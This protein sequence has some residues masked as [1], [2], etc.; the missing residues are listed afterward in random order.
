LKYEQV[1]ASAPPA[2]IAGAFQT[3]V[4]GVRSLKRRGVRAVMF[5][6]V[7][8]NPGFQSVYGPA[9]ACP[10]PDREPEAWRDFMLGLARQ[11]GDRPVLIPSSDKFVSAI[12]QHEAALAPHYRLSPGAAL[13]GALANKHS[14]YDLAMRFGMPMPVTRFAKNEDDVRDFARNAMFPCLI[15]PTH[16]REWQKLPKDHRLYDTKVAIAE[17]EAQLI[18]NYRLAVSV[19]PDVILQEIIVGPDTAK[20]VYLSCYDTAGKRIANAMFRELRCSPVGFGPASIS[21]P[22]DDPQ[23]DEVCDRWLRAINYVGLCEIEMKWDVRDGKVKI[24]EA[25]PR[26]SGGGDAAP[27]AGV[28]LPWI[29]YCDL[30]GLPV[31]PA[32]PNGKDFRH[33]VLRADGDA[34]PAYWFGG[35]IGFR[36]VLASYR[37]PRAFFDLDR[38]DWRYSLETFY[39][40]GRLIFRALVKRLFG[41]GA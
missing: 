7:T 11:L 17:N 22:V 27:Y 31:T 21:E 32:H 14:Q 3:G 19:T 6:S 2:V 15:K 13:Q 39:V 5:D 34:L 38:R 35:L 25:N 30:A 8:N 41:R 24:I 4:L 23:T 33:I 36:D 28:D 20:R 9:I 18:Q 37:G 29:Q 26:L 12:A 10:D 16:F 40:F 1:P